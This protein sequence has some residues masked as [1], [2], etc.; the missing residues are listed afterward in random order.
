[1]VDRWRLE[2][3]LWPSLVLYRRKVGLVVPIKSS[4]AMVER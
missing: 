3:L 2:G 1:M 4:G